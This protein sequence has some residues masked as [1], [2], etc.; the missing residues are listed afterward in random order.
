MMKLI[1]STLKKTLFWSYDRGSW[2]YDIMCVVI[3]GFI[4]LA[5][6]RVFEDHDVTTPIILRSEEVGGVDPQ[7]L[8]QMATMVKR[9]RGQSVTISRVEK[10]RDSLGE[11]YVIFQK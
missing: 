10:T 3:L 1:L 8:E 5:P 6:N 7:D 2:Q 11:V 9:I 4:I